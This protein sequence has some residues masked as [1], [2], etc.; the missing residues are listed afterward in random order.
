MKVLPGDAMHTETALLADHNPLM[1]IYKC[2]KALQ[3]S[4]M[5]KCSGEA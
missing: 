3:Q 2:I 1:Y 5:N 4:V